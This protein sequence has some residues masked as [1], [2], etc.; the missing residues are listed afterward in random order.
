MLSRQKVRTKVIIES[1]L[2]KVTFL[3]EMEALYL[4]SIAYSG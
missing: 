4:P 1:C 2:Y 3:L